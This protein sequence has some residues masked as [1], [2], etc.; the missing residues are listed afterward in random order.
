MAF[1]INDLHEVIDGYKIKTPKVIALK[2]VDVAFDLL[3]DINKEDLMPLKKGSS[4]KT[5]QANI[6]T[7]IAAGK[8]PDQAV[9]IAY[10][11][12]G[13]SNKKK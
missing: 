5:I 1:T 6:K 2:T 4:A 9:A 11:K 10:S 3:E 8:K 13:K 7:E 12:A